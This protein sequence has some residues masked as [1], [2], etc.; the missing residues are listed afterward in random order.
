VV[1]IEEAKV[2]EANEANVATAQVVEDLKN[3][4]PRAVE[5]I[6]NELEQENQEEKEAQVAIQVLTNLAEEEATKINTYDCLT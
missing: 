2:I 4:S 6:E 3:H 1:T 5:T